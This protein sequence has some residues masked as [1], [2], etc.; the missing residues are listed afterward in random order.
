MCAVSRFHISTA[1]TTTTLTTT[2]TTLTTT[3]TIKSRNPVKQL[4][5]TNAF[6]PR[7]VFAFTTPPSAA[8]VDM[9][10][11]VDVEDGRG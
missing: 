11:D 4:I 7:L 2:T 6:E 10:M 5:T 9:D 3:T 1:T 8:V